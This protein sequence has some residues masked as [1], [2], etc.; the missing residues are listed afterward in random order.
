MLFRSPWITANDRGVITDGGNRTV[1]F[2]TGSDIRAKD[3]ITE[4]DDRAIA[5]YDELTP[6]EFIFKPGIMQ[7]RPEEFRY[8]FSAQQVETLMDKY[9]ITNSHLAG[10]IDN[11]ETDPFRPYTG[12][13][14]KFIDYTS[15]HAFH[16]HYSHMLNKRIEALEKQI[17][18]MKGA[19]S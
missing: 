1:T 5:L 18:S 12:D 8:G 16:V 7:H 3:K 2:K 4:L 19:Q 14:S 13:T 9:G 11:S 15:F 10:D 17:A 6:L